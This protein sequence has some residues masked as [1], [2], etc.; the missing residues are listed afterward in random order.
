MKNK[1]KITEKD[2]REL[3]GLPYTFSKK[4]LKTVIEAVE[5][6]QLDMCTLID[7]IQGILKYEFGVKLSYYDCKKYLEHLKLQG[8]L[9]RENVYGELTYYII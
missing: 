4:T 8:I 5:I 3:G 7:D 6:G 1:I 2:M 9:G